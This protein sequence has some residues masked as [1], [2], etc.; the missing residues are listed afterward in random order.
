MLNKVCNFL[1]EKDNFLILTH[2]SPDGDTLG[3]AYAL[4]FGIKQLGKKARV[5]CGD[6]IPKKYSY[7]TAAATMDEIE[8]PTVIAVDVASTKLLG[9]LEKDYKNKIEL[10]IDHHKTNTNYA[11]LNY[12]DDSYGA[13][14]EIIYKILLELG[15]NITKVMA[16]ALYT[17]IS[18]DTGCF[19]FV[20]T[21][22]NT[23]KIAAKL[24]EMGINSSKIDR[25]MFDTKSINRIE[26]EKIAYQNLELYKNNKIAVVAITKSEF[27]ECG[28]MDDDFDGITTI[29]RS[30]E[31][32]QV[33]VTMRE[34][35]NGTV[36][37]SVRTFNNIDAALFCKQFGGGGHMGAAGCEIKGDIYKAKQMII[38]AAKKAIL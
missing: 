22:A 9:S 35:N 30:V 6:D 18:T 7:F 20:N 23:H 31:G 15:V 36:K 19:K 24:M 28:C 21:T 32:V 12:V 3:S 16:E 4:F 11:K 33:A 10:S 17:G 5:I 1:K 37:V 14:C 13:N 38:N 26:L 34:L 8:N 29:S 25:I 27:L 2:R